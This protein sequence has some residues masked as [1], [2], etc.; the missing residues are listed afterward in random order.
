MSDWMTSDTSLCSKLGVKTVIFSDFKTILE[1]LQKMKVVV[2]SL[3]SDNVAFART[4]SSRISELLVSTLKCG[5]LSFS[6][7]SYELESSQELLYSFMLLCHIHCLIVSLLQSI[8]EKDFTIKISGNTKNSVPCFINDPWLQCF[9][10]IGI[11][12]QCTLNIRNPELGRTLYKPLYNNHLVKP[13]MVPTSIKRK[14][15]LWMTG[16]FTK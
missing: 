1:Q 5:Q 4:Y 15:K 16:K 10:N 6:F 2:I 8:F 13:N 11:L 14:K 7:V 3:L 12:L 9:L